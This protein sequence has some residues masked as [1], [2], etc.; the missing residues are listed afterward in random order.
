MSSTSPSSIFFRLTTTLTA[1]APALALLVGSVAPGCGGWYE[2]FDPQE[3]SIDELRS[4]VKS[5]HVSCRRVIERYEDLRDRPKEALAQITRTFGIE[6]QDV[7]DMLDR[8]AVV[9]IGHNI[10]GMGRHV[11]LLGG[12]GV[13]T[14]FPQFLQ[15]FAPL[16]L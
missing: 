8:G 14:Q 12:V 4:Q 6:L 3:A 10:G 9:E 13:N 7:R 11:K 15:R 16:D 2:S 1:S 5:G